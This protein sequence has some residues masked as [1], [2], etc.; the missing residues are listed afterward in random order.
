MTKGFDQYCE[1]LL[2]E[3]MPAELGADFGSTSDTIKSSVPETA[4]YHWKALQ[5]LE[6]AKREEVINSIIQKVFPEKDFTYS[7]SIDDKKQLHAAVTQAIKDTA[8][9]IP[10][11]KP[12]GNTMIRFLADRLVGK[13]RLGNVTYT[14]AEGTEVSSGK[15]SRAEG[16]MTQSE[17][18]AKLKAAVAKADAGEELSAEADEEPKE[19]SDVEMVYTKAADISTDD[20]DLVR[21]FKKLPEGDMDWQKVL[22]TV[23]LSA[24]QKLLDIGALVETEKEASESDETEAKDLEFDEED[25]ADLSQF[26]KMIDPYFDYKGSPYRDTDY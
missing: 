24:A 6:P 7:S 9:E 11:F 4:T 15:S 21:A 23:G 8:Q 22:K 17:F 26:D 16:G 14:D 20:S 12:G 5:A 19:N 3:L 10:E 13:E 25:S 18:K 2:L 1:S